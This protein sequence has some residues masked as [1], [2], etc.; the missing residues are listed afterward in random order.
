[1][2]TLKGPAAASL[3]AL[4]AL[5]LAACSPRSEKAQPASET[6]ETGETSETLAASQAAPTPA[7]TFSIGS[8]S[9]VVVSDGGLDFPNDN[10]IFGVGRPPEDVAQVLSAAGLPADKLSLTVMPLLVKTSDRVL[11]FDTGAGANFGPSTGKLP[12]SLA[13]AGVDPG[14]VTDVFISHAH[15]DHAGGLV[16]ADGAL[17]FPNATIHISSADWAFLRGLNAESAANFGIGNHA[18]LVPAITPK[19]ATFAPGAELIPGAVKAVEIRGHT[20][21]H[22]GFLIGSGADSVLYTADTM[23]HFVISVQKPDWTVAFDGDAPTAQQS[24]KEVLAQSAANGQRIYGVHFPFPGIGKFEQR[25]D[26]YV[27]V[28]E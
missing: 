20:P 3:A 13:D 28:A 10:K 4:A 22:S 26:G 18:K 11:L 14:S 21:G 12:Q 23:H 6:I 7:G 19:V 5:T 16:N 27:W 1:M 25:A 9:A 2:Q 8:F 24:R 15:G 17:V